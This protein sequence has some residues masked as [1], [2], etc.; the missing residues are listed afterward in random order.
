MYMAK[1]KDKI[2]INKNVRYKGKKVPIFD[3]IN[4][5][6]TDLKEQ[7]PEIE[8]DRLLS[9][10]SHIRNY[11]YG[12]LYYGRRNVPENIKRKRELTK[13]EKFVLDYLL[14]NELNPS[15]TY[16]WFIACRMPSDIIEKLQKGKLSFRRAFLIAD[17]R[18]KSKLSN[19]G[20]LMME[21][22][23]NT[24]SSL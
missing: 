19:T 4:R 20:L 3:R 16:R 14:K 10:M 11:F 2:F 22:I 1:N 13:N 6:K 7:M 18:K 9:M 8:E 15:P 17:N 23:N 24:V 5:I 21:E 12:K